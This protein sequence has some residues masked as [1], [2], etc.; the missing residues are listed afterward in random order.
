MRLLTVKPAL[1]LLAC[2][3]VSSCAVVTKYETLRGEP[4]LNYSGKAY[5]KEYTLVQSQ[6]GKHGYPYWLEIEGTPIYF[7]TIR[8]SS[9]TLSAGPVLPIIPIP[10]APSDYGDNNLEVSF[11]AWPENYPLSFYPHQFQIIVNQSGERVTPSAIIKQLSYGPYILNS[12][13]QE[14]IKDIS[15]LLTMEKLHI[16]SASVWP[17]Y[18]FVFDIKLKEVDEFVIIPAPIYAQDKA[19]LLPDIHYVRASH[20]A[21]D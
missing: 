8:L 12:F 4:T 2:V 9:N 18:K 15:S 20:T 16:D 11:F 3:L 6:P 19:Y 5:A 14:T 7:A 13:A 1:L 10:D 17:I 21:Y